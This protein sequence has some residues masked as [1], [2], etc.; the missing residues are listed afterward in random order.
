MLRKVSL[1]VLF[2]VSLILISACNGGS[3]KG[4]GSTAGVSK[5][6]PPSL[7]N[8]PEES[9]AEEV[10]TPEV[11][12]EY[13]GMGGIE[14]FGYPAA[15]SEEGVQ[16]VSSRDLN[17]SVYQVKQG[18]MIDFIAKDF[19]ISSSAIISANQISNTRSLQIGE[20]LKIPSIDG[21]SYTVNS[22]DSISGIASRFEIPAEDILE[23]NNLSEDS[24]LKAG[25]NLFLPGAELDKFALA[26]I[27]GDLFRKPIR[28][29]YYISSYYGWRPSP[30]TG[31]R[32]WHNGLDMACP[33]GTT[34]YSAMDGTVE[35][36]G[37]SN[38]Y[39]NYVRIKH[40]SGYVTLYGHMLKPSNMKKGRSYPAGSIVGYV[41]STGQSTGP[42]LHFS[43]FKYG[44]GKNPLYLMN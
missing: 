31:A 20:Y 2:L 10:R 29:W 41:G 40:H 30:F 22:G 7:E 11:P 19:G 23:V 42:H 13:S 28:S 44:T 33:A 1:S 3:D 25:I 43:V 9:E 16:G 15:Y 5:V 32:S 8:F 38:V 24:V 34:I 12:A 39:G 18:D 35:S 27:N 21:I 14:T 37:W 17:Y 6:V 4:T 36:A 26:E